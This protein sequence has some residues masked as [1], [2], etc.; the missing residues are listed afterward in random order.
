[1]KKN[2]F[3]IVLTLAIFSACKNDQ[4]TENGN[5]NP[6]EN[7]EKSAEF[8]PIQE[9]FA[10]TEF[11]S[12]TE[13]ELLKEI[14]ICSDSA[15]VPCSAENFKFFPL[16]KNQGLENGFI[17]L[18]KAETGG[19]PLRRVLVFEREN[20]KL[21]KANGFVANLIGRHPSSGDYDD[22]LLRFNDKDQG[23]DIFYNCLFH[24]E[25][26]RYQFKQ[27]EVIQGANWGG[28]V[29]P[30]F[31]DSVSQEVYQTIINNQMIF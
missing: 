5:D 8:V 1:M 24:W 18:I 29:K 11:G 20:G 25:K 3:L 17:L 15:G 9:L 13:P 23:E 26:G 7:V 31:K 6:V 12:K 14:K 2:F 27:V 21:V 28:P 10:E 22:L 16:K 19:F 30:E 4:G